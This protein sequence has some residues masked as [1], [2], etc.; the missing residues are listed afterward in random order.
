LEPLQGFESLEVNWH[1]MITTKISPL[2]VLLVDDDSELIA[3]VAENLRNQGISADTVGTGREALEVLERVAP[4]VL[5][6]DVMLPDANGIDL[7]RRLRSHGYNMPILMLTARS[8][9]IDRVLG[10]EFGADD[11]LSKPFESRELVARI[12]ALHRRIGGGQMEAGMLKFG[13]LSIDLVGLRVVYSGVAVELTASEFKLLTALALEPAKPI[14]REQLSKAIQPKGYLPLD[15]AVD[16][17]IARLR[18]KLS[19]VSAGREWIITMRG[20]GYAFTGH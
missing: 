4:S 18:K 15:R 16:V 5:V 1:V 17:K 10:L 14:S 8:D 7:C 2:S 13:E 6:L 19:D 9:P 3:M 20:L 11:Y 12:R